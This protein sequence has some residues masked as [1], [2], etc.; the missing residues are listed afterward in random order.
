MKITGIKT[1]IWMRIHQDNQDRGGRM[2]STALSGVD[3]A[4]WGLGG[5]VLGVHVHALLGGLV[6]STKSAC[7][8]TGWHTNPGTPAQNAEEA[9]R[10]GRRIPR[11]E[12]A[13]PARSRRLG[14]RRHS[15]NQQRSGELMS[16]ALC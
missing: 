8:P 5:K 16:D 4:L 11:V 9:P 13:R 15:R 6:L 1:N 2:F 7:T 12:R 3:T 10:F 14:R